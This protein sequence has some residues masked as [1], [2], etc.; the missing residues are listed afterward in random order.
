MRTDSAKLSPKQER[1][2]QEYL[3]DLNA[4]QAAI[5]AGYS[6]KTAYSIGEENL[7]KPDIQDFLAK[8]KARLLN[9]SSSRAH[10][11]LEGLERIVRANILDYVDLSDPRR[12]VFALS[13]ITR[14]QGALIQEITFHP[15]T[16][17][18]QIKL[19][20]K[21]AALAHLGPF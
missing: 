5:R 17:R 20:D 21:I 11:V 19:Y 6:R 12:P 13:K 1:F 18:S 9:N 10:F 15:R 14:D 3:V 2:V 8:A 7:K 16:G 4:T